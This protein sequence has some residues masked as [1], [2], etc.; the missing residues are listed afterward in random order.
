MIIVQTDSASTEY[1]LAVE[2]AGELRRSDV[3]DKELVDDIFGVLEWTQPFGGGFKTAECVQKLIE[4]SS[5]AAAT[6][7]LAMKLSQAA[8]NA[9]NA[10]RVLIEAEKAILPG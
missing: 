3:S 7:D 8:L 2:T 4:A 6:P 9:G 1:A 5:A 10:L